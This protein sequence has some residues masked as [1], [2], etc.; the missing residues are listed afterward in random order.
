MNTYNRKSKNREE[1]IRELE[2]TNVRGSFSRASFL[3]E[4]IEKIDG[5]VW[6]MERRCYHPAI[7]KTN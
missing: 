7:T 2:N 6:D 4:R 1:L 5:I 3:I